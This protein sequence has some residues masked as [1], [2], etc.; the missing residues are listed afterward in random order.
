MA[1][2]EAILSGRALITNPVGFKDKA[3]INAIDGSW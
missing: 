2:A 3:A 1:A